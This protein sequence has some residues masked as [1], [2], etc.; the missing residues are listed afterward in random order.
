MAIHQA[1]HDPAVTIVLLPTTGEWLQVEANPEGVRKVI[2][3]KDAARPKGRVKLMQQNTAKQSGAAAAA[4]AGAMITHLLPMDRNGDHTLADKGG[5]CVPAGLDPAL[6]LYTSLASVMLA[7]VTKRT[8]SPTRAGG[9][10]GWNS[11]TGARG[12]PRAEPNVLSRNCAA[13]LNADDV[14]AHKALHGKE[15]STSSLA[16]T[17][18]A[19]ASPGAAASPAQQQVSGATSPS[20]GAGPSSAAIP[21]P[22]IQPLVT[23]AAFYNHASSARVDLDVRYAEKDWAKRLGAK[24]D[25]N[26]NRQWYVPP[27]LLLSRFVR[28]LPPPPAAAQAPTVQPAQASPPAPHM[29]AATATVVTA[30]LPAPVP[31]PVMAQVVATATTAA[32]VA[33]RV[34]EAAEE[35]EEVKLVGTRTREERD[36]EGRRNA[37]V[38][39]EELEK[40]MGCA[41]QAST[42]QSVKA[43]PLREEEEGR[44]P[45][46][47][48]T[49]AFSE[50]M[51]PS[52]PAVPPSAP[53]T[54]PP[55]ASP[56]APHTTP[57]AAPPTTAPATLPVPA[58][59]PSAPPASLSPTAHAAGQPAQEAETLGSKIS[60]IR[61]TLELEPSVSFPATLREAFTQLELGPPSAGMGLPSQADAVLRALG[62]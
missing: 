19:V 38:L 45:K 14:A 54:A 49:E 37:V 26:G 58:L 16:A 34:V 2:V 11:F 53:P 18:A 39:E 30:T 22:A 10:I 6:H 17:S 31:V 55:A 24:F 27:G 41:S 21:S 56:A 44:T 3:G 7:Q 50:S 9:C 5:D 57:P 28:W 12:Y 42:Q 8:H 23:A 36:A 61:A 46:R 13:V 40:D 60:R 20:G 51:S 25:F 33:H 52:L 29:A 32:A 59:P 35:E 4:R 47:P 62:V 15:F 48:K 1:L 43:E